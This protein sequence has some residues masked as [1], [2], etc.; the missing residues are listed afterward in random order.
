MATGAEKRSPWAI[1]PISYADQGDLPRAVEHYE[2]Q[3]SIARAIG[4]RKSEATGA[5]NLGLIYKQRGD[6]VLALPLLQVLVMYEREIGHPDTEE[7]ARWF[8]ALQ[9]SVA[10]N[11]ELNGSK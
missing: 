1:W 2:Q 5:W 11:S 9:Q 10:E 6:Y 3:I 7:R 4:D 8:A